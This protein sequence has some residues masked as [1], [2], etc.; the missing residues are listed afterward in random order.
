[1]EGRADGGRPQIFA[2]LRGA[3]QAPLEEKR[4]YG[5]Q[6]CL[7]GEKILPDQKPCSK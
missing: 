1:M 3:T 7:N 4:C 2:D 6:S 5:D